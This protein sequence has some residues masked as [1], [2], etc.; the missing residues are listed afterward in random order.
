MEVTGRQG[1]RHKQ[2]LYD[3]KVRT[4][5]CKLK[6]EALDRTVW[7][8]RFARGCGPVVRLQNDGMCS[9]GDLSRLLVKLYQNPPPDSRNVVCRY[10]GGGGS[11]KSLTSSRLL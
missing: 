2:L 5:F 7:R 1:R 3:L 11:D 4:G 9:I 8:T 10:M 6:E